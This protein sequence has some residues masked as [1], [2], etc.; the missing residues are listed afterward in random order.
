MIAQTLAIRYPQRTLSL[1]SIMSNT[2]SFWNGQPALTMYAVLLKPAP[3]DRERFINHAVEHVHE[4]RR[5]GLS[6]PT[7]RTCATI[8]TRSYDR[9]AR[10]ARLAA[11]ARGD[12]RR[13]RPHAALRRLTLPATVIH[14]AEDKLVRPSGGRATAKRDP[15]RAAGGDR[16]HG[17]RPAARRLADRSSTRSPTPRGARTR[18]GA[19]HQHEDEHDHDQQQQHGAADRARPATDS[20]RSPGSRGRACGGP[21]AARRPSRRRRPSATAGRSRARSARPCRCRGARGAAG[22][23]RD[24]PAGS[25]SRSRSLACSTVPHDPRSRRPAPRPPRPSAP[26]RARRTP[27]RRRRSRRS[28]SP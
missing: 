11:P 13:P 9:G 8:A 22:R 27:P 24:T 17:P 2:G 16:R 15:R 26:R 23:C 21:R 4:D 12:R 18:G 20:P 14:G 7:S 3:R 19:Q 1:V 6:R 28:S 25:N 5:H 10:P